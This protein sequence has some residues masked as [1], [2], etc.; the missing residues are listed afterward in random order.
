LKYFV[1]LRG[2]LLGVTYSGTIPTFKKLKIFSTIFDRN[3]R[4]FLGGVSLMDVRTVGEEQL[5]ST[6]ITDMQLWL[7]MVELNWT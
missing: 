4:K 2:I 5:Y 1:Q 7:Y 6:A 3:V